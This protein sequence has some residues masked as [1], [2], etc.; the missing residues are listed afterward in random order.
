MV[1]SEIKFEKVWL[2][3]FAD[4]EARIYFRKDFANFV[5]I[6]I[7]TIDFI[8]ISFFNLFRIISRTVWPGRVSEK[9]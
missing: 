6:V 1:P 2:A 5:L 8:L 3:I 9:D 7:H 4:T